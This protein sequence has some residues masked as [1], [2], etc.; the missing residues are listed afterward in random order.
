MLGAV[1]LLILPKTPKMCDHVVALS[2]VCTAQKIYYKN[3]LVYSSGS[4]KNKTENKVKNYYYN[5]TRIHL[6]I[7]IVRKS[8]TPRGRLLIAPLYVL[9]QDMCRSIVDNLHVILSRHRSFKCHKHCL[10]LRQP[11][12]VIT[13]LRST[14]IMH[15]TSFFLV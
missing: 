14:R 11:N 5:Y 13:T 10:L 3:K 4:H 8:Q 9:N 7:L 12:L 6:K 1:T 15:K 2:Q